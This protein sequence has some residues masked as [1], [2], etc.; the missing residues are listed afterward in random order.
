MLETK[1]LVKKFGSKTAVDDISFVVEPGKT[2]LL[3]G[4]NGSGKTTWMKTAATL[5]K[6]T[7]GDVYL[8]GEPVGIN[9]RKKISYMPTE[10][11]FYNWMRVADVGTY[12]R[13]FFEDFDTEKFKEMLARLDLA[14]DA[15]VQDLSS[16]MNAK[17][18]LAAAMSRYASVYLLDEPL[19]GIDLVARDQVLDAVIGAMTPDAAI[20]ISSHL[21]EEVESIASTAVF[22]R[23]GKILEIRDTEDLRDQ[24]GLSLADRYRQLMQ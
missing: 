19:N 20:V 8:D 11:Y 16:G 23:H 14:P 22:I 10:S 6:P 2:Y 7:S 9:S 4:P 1:N 15:R 18:R 5:T 3:L 21:V 17:L 12:Y 13:D 24:T